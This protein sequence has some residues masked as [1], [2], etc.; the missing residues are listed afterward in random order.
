MR[1]VAQSKPAL[2]VPFS[3][4]CE[5]SSR[6]LVALAPHATLIAH[7]KE[8]EHHAAVK[9]AIERFLAEHTLR[10]ALASV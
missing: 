4:D 2:P 1:R 6:E 5:A 8:P 10:Q 3:T 9:Q 7:W